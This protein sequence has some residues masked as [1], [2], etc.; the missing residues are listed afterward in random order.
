MTPHT[1][2]LPLPPLPHGF[3]IF[4]DRGSDKQGELEI[5]KVNC[6]D[7]SRNISDLIDVTSISDLID[8][9]SPAFASVCASLWD[10]QV[11]ILRKNPHRRLIP[12]ALAKAMANQDAWRV[13]AVKRLAAL[14]EDHCNHE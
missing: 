5:S 3:N 7:S 14:V 10:Y 1:L 4:H 11:E 13:E 9:T 6:I 12:N 2:P 8:V